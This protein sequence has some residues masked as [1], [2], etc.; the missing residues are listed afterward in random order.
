MRYPAQNGAD[1]TGVRRVRI[2]VN[3]DGNWYVPPSDEQ[4]DSRIPG[5]TIDRELAAVYTA[6]EA[7]ALIIDLVGVFP[8][9]RFRVDEQ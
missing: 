8:K 6:P 7:Y 2:C 1:S 5:Q 4:F 9:F 3:R